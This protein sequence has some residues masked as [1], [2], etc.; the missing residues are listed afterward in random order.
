M[1]NNLIDWSAWLKKQPPTQVYL[2]VFIFVP[3]LYIFFMFLT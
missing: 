2:Q 1:N 3:D